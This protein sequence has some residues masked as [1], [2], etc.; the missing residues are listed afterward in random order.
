MKIKKITQSIVYNQES[1]KL[2]FRGLISTLVFLSL[3]Y[4]Y[5]IGS[6]TF[7]V[8]ARKSL[9]TNARALGSEV[10]SLELESMNMQNSITRST[11]TNL[12]FVDSKGTLFASRTITDYV[13]SR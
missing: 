10:A 3:T 13:A 1:Q 8:L 7:N 12:G 6:I 9:D 4:V 11:G 2:V 5:L